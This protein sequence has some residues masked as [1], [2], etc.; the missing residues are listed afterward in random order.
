MNRSETVTMFNDL[1]LVAPAALVDADL[2]WRTVGDRAVEGTFSNA[3]NTIRA[4]LWFDDAGDLCDF[5]SDDRFMSADGKSY[6]S[7]PWSTP[8]GGYRDYGGYR[9]ASRGEA[10]WRRPD[11]DFVYA[12]LELED[13]AYDVELQP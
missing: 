12:R 9:L 13:V 7:H 11:G 2:R 4:L 5:V 8:V 3:G 1:C 10:R 6:V